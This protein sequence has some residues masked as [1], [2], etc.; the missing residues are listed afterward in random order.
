MVKKKDEKEEKQ[1]AP[2]ESGQSFQ[3]KALQRLQD[4]GD[5]RVP[6]DPANFRPA[7]I[8]PE[9]LTPYGSSKEESA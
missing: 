3:E 4:Q 7:D 1:E 9:P 6:S 5:T 2:Q 8:P